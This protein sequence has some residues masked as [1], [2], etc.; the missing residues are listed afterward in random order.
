M[1]TDNS[2]LQCAGTI[3]WTNSQKKVIKRTKYCSMTV[4]LLRN[5]FR[6]LILSLESGKSLHKFHLD[7]VSIH[8]KFI[9][10][11]KATINF[12]KINVIVMLS[13]APSAQLVPFLKTLFIKIT[14][15]KQSPKVK[16]REQLLSDKPHALEE[17]S[18]VNSKDVK[19]V[20]TDVHLRDKILIDLQLKKKRAVD[21][22]NKQVGV[23]SLYLCNEYIPSQEYI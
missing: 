8:K 17:I 9:A 1:E 7:N 5:E 12:S 14:S 4:K 2:I 13:N 16:L 6:E 15:K 19:R 20:K 21:D 23:S 3:E 18:P 11:G 22:Q 10:E